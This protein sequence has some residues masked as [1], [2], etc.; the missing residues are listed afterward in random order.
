MKLTIWN[1]NNQLYNTSQIAS[2]LKQNTKV[3]WYTEIQE[4][5]DCA[6]D[7]RKNVAC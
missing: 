4:K 1:K 7:Y 2:T 3:N 6:N 5:Q